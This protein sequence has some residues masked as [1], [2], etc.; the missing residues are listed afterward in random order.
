MIRTPLRPLARILEARQKGENP[1]AI[2]RENKRIRHEQMRDASR[3]RAEGRLLVLGV[4]FFCAFTVV[5]ARMGVMATTDPTEPRA[6]APGSVISAT[7][8]D[9]VDRNGNLLATNFETHALYAQPHHMIDPQGA[10]KKLMA[11]FPDLN[12]ERL[13]RD[14]TGKRK[15]LWIKKKISPEQMQAVHDIGE[16]GLLFAPRDMRLYPNG[17]LAA[18]IMG[19]ASYGREGVHAAEVIGVAGAEKYFDDYLRDPANGNKPL[20]LSIDMTVQAASERIL[21][22]GMK[23]MNAKGATSVLMDVHTGEVISAVSLPSFDPND[24][25]RAAV[26]GDA[27]DSPLFNRSVQGVY[28]LGSVFKIFTAAQAIDLG[29]ATADT[30]IDTS[31]PMKVG[32]FRIGEFHGK[33]YGKQTVTGIIVHSSNRG[34]GRLALEI[35]AE[36]Q[37]EFLKNLGFFEP[38][39]FEIIEASGGKPL[40]PQRW[41]ELSTVTVSY[42]HGLSSSPMH[43]AAGYS[44]IANGGH[45]VTPTLRKQS[46]P[47]VGPRV[48]SERAAADARA[49]LRAVVTE[50]TASFAEVPGYQIGG[51]T[52]TADKPGPRG[53]Y[54]EDKV[55]AT[56]A[57]MFPAHDPKYV[58]IVTLDEPVETSGDKPRRTAGWTAVPVAAEM[59][60]RVAPLLGLRPTVEPDSLADI[61]LSSS[62]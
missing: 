44:A 43:L 39:P 14:F 47:V 52:G 19:G 23:L 60:R 11:V 8:A 29:I 46:G 34:T 10:V 49:M 17:S 3:Q 61:T 15:F 53:G 48:M 5:G 25:P 40:L 16:P 31:G 1:D 36:R 2:E 55:I 9:I 38:T 33:N 62:N 35:G 6:A 30:V 12:E 57:S 4:F 45:K 7:R 24:R 13:L 54:L 20:E 18:H 59:V 32:G 41:Q 51:K 22:G 58:L 26:T 56:F 37:Q 42:G 27:S 21:Y 28:E 50:G